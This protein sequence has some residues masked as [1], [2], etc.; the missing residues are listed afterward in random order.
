MG[1]LANPQQE[2]QPTQV[3]YDPEKQQY[4]S[5]KPSPNTNSN[6]LN[7]MFGFNT[8][9]EER[10]Y[11]NN[12]FMTQDRFTPT[13]VPANYP[14]MN[15]LFPALN[16]GLVQNLSNSLLT[17]TDNTQSSGVGRFLAP[18]NTSQGK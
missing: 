6:V 5:Y 8:Q 2:N 16:A 4:F 3:Y 15:E 7:R 12:P 14:Y 1:T 11:L 17:P 10:V 13:Y 9:D 18:S